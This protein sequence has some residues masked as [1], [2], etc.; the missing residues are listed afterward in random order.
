MTDRVLIIDDDEGMVRAL[1]RQFEVEGFRVLAACNGV[2]GLH[3]L[4]SQ[5]PSL[6]LLDLILPCMSGWELC[7]RIRECS[8]VPIIMLTALARNEDKVHGLEL[9]ADDYVTK[10]FHGHEL[11]ARVRAVLRRSR[12]PLHENLT[13]RIDDHLLLDRAR[14]QAIVEGQRVA[15]SP[16]EYQLLEYFVDNLGRILTHQSILSQIWGWEYTDE[17]SYLKVYVCNLRK[18]IERNP[19]KP[20]YILT[21][22]GL[23]YRFQV[24]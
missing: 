22:R 9:G 14:C 15:L 20:E 8:D 6:V 21:E 3:I 19:R 4:Q 18:K 23:G 2:E 12:N 11:I 16:V 24:P 1:R 13:I 7:H 17:R 5:Y 10:P